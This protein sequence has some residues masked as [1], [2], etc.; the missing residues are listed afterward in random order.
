MQFLSTARPLV[1]GHRPHS[2]QRARRK[3]YQL[4]HPIVDALGIGQQILPLMGIGRQA[5]LEHGLQVHNAV[6][7][8]LQVALLGASN[9]A[10]GDL[11]DH[12]GI[13]THAALGV[14]P[15][16]RT[17]RRRHSSRAAPGRWRPRVTGGVSDSASGGI[18]VRSE[19]R[20][21]G[22]TVGESVTLQEEDQINF[23]IST[24]VLRLEREK[25]MKKLSAQGFQSKPLPISIWSL[26]FH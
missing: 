4:R 23:S 8:G 2:D 25:K 5:A 17:F 24:K 22:S 1:H 20:E 7:Q 18:V 15:S 6:L 13:P 10:L 19:Y 16:Q 26:C 14:L 11:T 12:I 3:T 21:Y 9:T